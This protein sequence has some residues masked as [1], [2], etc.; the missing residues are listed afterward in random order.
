METW[1]LSYPESVP[2]V[3]QIVVEGDG[4][5]GHD[6]LTRAVAVASEACPGARL[7]RRDRTWVD[8]GVAPV[9]RSVP[10]AEFD[11]TKF[12]GVPE[13]Y[14]PLMR[15]GDGPTCEVLLIT[16]DPC[17]VVF[18]AFHGVMDSKGVLLWLEDV[19]R[20]LRGEPPVGAPSPITVT[21]LLDGVPVPPRPGLKSDMEWPSALGP[22]TPGRPGIFWRRRT[23]DGVHPALVAKV[24][25]AITRFC[26]RDTG[27]FLV[28]V[29]LRRYLPD[30]RAT[31][32]LVQTPLMEV[33]GDD[34]WETA[35]E[36][37]LTLL[38][39]GRDLAATVETSLLD[40]PLAK[41]RE[42]VVALDSFSA[43]RDRY[44]AL[45]VVSHVGR[46]DLTGLTTDS[47]V[48][49][50]IYGLPSLGLVGPPELNI[51]ECGQRTEITVGWYNGPTVIDE[52]EKLLDH[53]EGA[54]SPRKHRQWAGNDTERPQSRP[55]TVVDWFA[56]QAAASGGKVALAGPEGDV[57]FAELDRRSD[58]IAA[59]LTGRGL[60]RGSV[61][62]IVAARTVAAV[63]G[64]WG[65]LKA[66]AA[67][68]PLDPEQ[69]D[70]RIT[71]IMRDAG[72]AAGLVERAFLDRPLAPAGC[73]LLALEDLAANTGERPDVEIRPDDL[74][75][76]IYTSGSTGR[77]KGVEVT[78]GNLAAFA[79]WAIPAFGIDAEIRFPLFTS[80][81]F[82]L[83]NTA[84][85]LPL[86]A[87][88]SI[89]LVPD[90][91][92]HLVLRE[93][94][95]RSGANA[96][97]VTP[98]HL[99]LINRL[100]LKPAG[101]RV[102]ISGGEL[103]TGA[104]AAR[105]QRTFGEDCRIYNEYGPTEATVACTSHLFDAAKESEL[106]SVPIGVPG[107]NTKIF[108]LN[109]EGRHVEIGEIGEMYLS[110]AQVARGYRGRPELNHER[111]VTLADGTRAYRTGDLARVLPH[112]ELECLGRNDEQ[113]KLLG[114]RVEPAETARVLEGHDAVAG[115]F[116]LG[117]A[118][119]AGGDK[120]LCAYVV[121]REDV[122][123]ADLIEYL[124]GRL[125]SYLVPTAIVVVPELPLTANGKVNASALPDPFGDI[126]AAAPV[127]TRVR[128]DVEEAVAK[129]W[130]GTLML[131]TDEVN[132]VADFHQLGGNSATLL[133]ML[134][135]V[136]SE[137]VGG[138]QER[139]FLRKLPLIIRRPTLEYV[140]EL[141]RE[142]RA[143]ARPPA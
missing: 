125:P 32:N 95:E 83:P 114:H 53:L 25:Q 29:D 35:H 127:K 67:Y 39:S 51:V 132:D 40:I 140:S 28:P 80:L 85:Y 115:A 12:S 102:V 131:E 74:A 5:I 24:T 92:N 20:V 33:R 19:F 30:V 10:G 124:R 56:Q 72:C 52:A 120:S 37:L 128:D 18:R 82:D 58:A 15:D 141:A 46:I 61:V 116:A 142:A 11:R 134:A 122:P 84:I 26:G 6:E 143:A 139:N 16:G 65:V 123:V 64:I 21:E 31:G 104:V 27:R 86:L 91:P 66:G 22:R 73:G 138:G 17:V 81:A 77:A 93:M 13:L 55:G 135:A 43:K 136:S 110:G 112:G 50:V 106:A 68:V 105:A 90:A 1:F 103:L 38:S 100:D 118:R 2:G 107:D 4:R 78:H 111:F 36:A 96:L 3:I 23:V 101:F 75:Y 59:E 89:A 126:V 60:G 63:A 113:F 8:T 97:K 9:V 117:H 69:P 94:L 70:H 88:G 129:I 54:L 121:L 44:A 71:E 109:G 45:A 108:L 99:D 87:G 14:Q 98:T 48:A 42:Q 76:V 47:F 41:L 34:S 7:A 79:G 119:R 133:A 62:G 130:A 57:T 49:K 137:V